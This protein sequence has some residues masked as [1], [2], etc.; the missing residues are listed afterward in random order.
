MSSIIS[1]HTIIANYFAR[2]N[3]NKGNGENNVVGRLLKRF[4]KLFASIYFPLFFKSVARLNPPV[5]WKGGIIHHLLKPGGAHSL[6][7]GYR[8]IMLGDITG[9]CL[10]KFIR[11]NLFKFAVGFAGPAQFASGMNGGETAF[12][13][14]YIRLIAEIA[15]MLQFSCSILF[16]DVVNAFGSMLRRIVFDFEEGDEAWLRKLSC[17]GFSK[18]D[19]GYIYNMVCHEA[20]EK[21]AQDN[22]AYAGTRNSLALTKSF[23]TN[24][25]F[26]QDHLRGAV[27]TINGCMAG[28]PLAD[29][30]FGIVLARVL[31]IVRQAMESNEL[32]SGFH[33]ADASHQIHNVAFADDVAV[34]IVCT[35][36]DVVH[37]TS[38]VAKIF[39]TVFAAFGLSLNFSCNKSE[40]LVKFCGPGAKNSKIKLAANGGSS[41]FESN[42]LPIVL[43]F[44]SCYKHMGTRF[45][46]S[47]DPMPDVVVRNQL[48]RQG[49]K[50]FS[51]IF[52]NNNI[53]L[54][55]KLIVLKAYLLSGGTYQ[56]STWPIL[57][58]AAYAK[59]HACIVYLYRMVTGNT[60]KVITEGGDMFNDE[61]LIQEYSLVAPIVMIRAARLQLFG[62]VVSKNVHIICSLF[63]VV[64][65]IPNNRCKGWFAALAGDFEWLSLGAKVKAP[66]SWIEAQ[67][68]VEQD[69]K[70]FRKHV[71]S[72][73][74]S[75][76]ANLDVPR[77][78]PCYRPIG[79]HN[80]SCNVCNKVFN[81][82]QSLA[83]HE[84]KVH[85][86]KDCLRKYVNTVFCPICMVMFH[87]RER[88]LNHLKYRSPTCK[89][90]ILL[91]QPVLTEEEANNLDSQ[92]AHNFVLMQKAGKRRHHCDA[93][94]YRLQ[95]P[96]PYVICSKPTNHH[97]LGFGH[98]Y[99]N[100]Y[101][102]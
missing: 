88:L 101:I 83:L 91:G 4:P 30:V 43:R 65:Q 70:R 41:M 50:A 94:A 10:N 11:N 72:F 19:I 5:Q 90:N 63:K 98:N 85:G 29:I 24:T 66:R 96:T 47:L 25:W 45:A 60:F 51:R 54:R 61:A 13:H 89:T 69:P 46:D 6:P 49:A 53:P 8:D 81:T 77:A 76:F 32:V 95:G 16:L 14:L 78:V 37:K 23:Y 59:F 26:T 100:A 35:A 67:N 56:C 80:F 92:D 82:K 52:R 58:K 55:T 38:Q 22:E 87:T 57:S 79:V 15:E 62:R 42:G 40:A 7:K 33:V 68:L 9:K 71:R 64:D 74:S 17:A 86:I 84:F 12:A 102:S 28:M 2:I 48:M 93:P 1:P 44:V 97:C 39:F 18:E 99:R 36:K 75:K 20:Y 73:A 31:T 21:Q 34:G 3:P 27:S